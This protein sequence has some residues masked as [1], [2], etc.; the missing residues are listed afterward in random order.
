M[1]ILGI[2]APNCYCLACLGG[3][4]ALQCRFWA[5][6]RQSMAIA[7]TAAPGHVSTQY[8]GFFLCFHYIFWEREVRACIFLREL[9]IKELKHLDNER[10]S[11]ENTIINVCN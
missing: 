8:L 2:A 9:N 1:P 3:A 11:M 7:D 5:L 6:H 10:K 4:M